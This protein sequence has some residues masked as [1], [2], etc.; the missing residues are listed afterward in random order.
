MVPSSQS[1][2]LP[3]DQPSA[4]YLQINPLT[5]I[6]MNHQHIRQEL[7]PVCLHII[8]R[9]APVNNH[10]KSLQ[11]ALQIVLHR[12]HLYT[13]PT[14]LRI[15]QQSFPQKSHLDS[16]LISRLRLLVIICLTILQSSHRWARQHNQRSLLVIF[17][18]HYLV[19]LHQQ[20]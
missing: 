12:I 14:I 13:H 3:S 19:V 20:N 9:T 11:Q 2:G 4:W 1:S 18:R 8:H 5:L 7:L 6:Q 10:H 17:Q 16:H 15:A